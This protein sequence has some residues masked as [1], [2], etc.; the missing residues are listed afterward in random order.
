ME[1]C[2]TILIRARYLLYISMELFIN[3]TRSLDLFKRI[4]DKPYQN[5]K[6]L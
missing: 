5:G 1:C 6:Y 2:T 4:K 3:R